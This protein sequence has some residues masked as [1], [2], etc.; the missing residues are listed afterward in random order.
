MSIMWQSYINATLDCFQ[1][2]KYCQAIIDIL[3]LLNSN[4]DSHT[5]K[6]EDLF[7]ALLNN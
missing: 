5:A 7:K 3:L 1:R 2:G 6:L 4:K